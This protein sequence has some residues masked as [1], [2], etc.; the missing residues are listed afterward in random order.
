MS[1]LPREV[2]ALQD[3]LD[4]QDLINQLGV[5]LD[6]KRI[7]DLAD[8]FAGDVEGRL[9]G[10]DPFFSIAEIQEHARRHLPQWAR[11]QHVFT[12]I[13]INL[14]GDTA[15]LR[16]NLINMHVAD[17][18]AP[19]KHFDF[20]GYYQITVRR[21]PVGWRISNILLMEIWRGGESPR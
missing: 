15:S 12:N 17:P 2:Q 7:D 13:L 1:S 10:G 6:E 14:E 21:D 3:R 19:D 5:Y 16:A 20:G 11:L 9:A 4:I 8:I 18:D